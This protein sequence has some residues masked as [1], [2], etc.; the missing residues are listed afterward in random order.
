V[1][2]NLID[3]MRENLEVM[4]LFLEKNKILDTEYAH[5]TLYSLLPNRSIEIR[6]AKR[7]FGINLWLV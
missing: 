7:F 5:M 6:D 1:S 4:K 3:L 2:L